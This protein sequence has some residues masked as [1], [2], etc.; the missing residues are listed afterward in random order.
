MA[1]YKSKHTGAEIDTSIDLVNDSTKGNEALKTTLDKKANSSDLTSHTSNTS[2]PHNV[3]KSQV[4]LGNVDNTSD[5]SK[6]ISTATQ[7]ALDTETTER[8]AQD[9]TL[10]SNI[11]SNWSTLMANLGIGRWANQTFL[12][13]SWV[14][15]GQVADNLSSQYTNVS[16]YCYGTK[17]LQLFN[18][19]DILTWYLPD[20]ST[21]AITANG[22]FY[23][24]NMETLVLGNLQISNPYAFINNCKALKTIKVADGKTVRLIDGCFSTFKDLPLLETIEGLTLEYFSDGY[25]YGI[26]LF[27]NCPKL[28]TIKCKNIN[29]SLHIN[30]LTSLNTTED[31]HNLIS[32]MI[33]SS[34]KTL[35]VNS[36]QNEVLS[37]ED[38]TLLVDTLGW[39]ISVA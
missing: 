15:E 17:Y 27:D 7:T 30:K 18:N 11:D 26:P 19:T 2:N 9:T 1:I 39:T 31:M 10:Q 34:N 16:R 24:C 21:K 32:G 6:P 35:Y 25:Q 29:S 12:S 28:K 3:T 33:K 20:F 4:G 23:D 36:T 38:R 14:S 13:G 5:L 37:D 22:M 8:K